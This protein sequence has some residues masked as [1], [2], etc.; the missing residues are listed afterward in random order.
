MALLKVD[1]P[2]LE[3]PLH[4]GGKIGSV[5]GND[6]GLAGGSGTQHIQQ[7]RIAGVPPQGSP[8]RRG[9]A[10]QRRQ[11]DP[12]QHPAGARPRRVAKYNTGVCLHGEIVVEL[13]RPVMEEG[14]VGEAAPKSAKHE[15]QV[16]KLILEAKPGGTG[17]GC[18]VAK[19]PGGL[20]HQRMQVPETYRLIARDD[21]SRGWM[22]PGKF[23]DRVR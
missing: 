15:Y 12:V 6:P 4:H 19:P 14:D 23:V 9:I 16:K 8:R 11:A 5:I 13:V 7:G 2:H 20:P 3:I 10:G 21:R 18:G 22:A 1:R 17:L